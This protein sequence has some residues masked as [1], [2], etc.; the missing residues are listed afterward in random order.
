M[1]AV[2]FKP[3]NIQQPTPAKRGSRAGHF[4]SDLPSLGFHSGQH[5]FDSG[6]D[7]DAKGFTSATLG[8][9]KGQNAVLQIHAI[10]GDLRL[11]ETAA[12]SQGD[13]EADFHPFGHTFHSQS[14]PGDFNLII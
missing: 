10:K 12:R 2:T 13:L 7:G 9:G 1:K 3:A 8:A 11:T 4:A 6:R 5:G 14:F